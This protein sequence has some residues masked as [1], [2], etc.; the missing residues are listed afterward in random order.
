M[1]AR[2]RASA[3]LQGLQFVFGALSGSIPQAFLYVVAGGV[4]SLAVTFGLAVK[5]RLPEASFIMDIVGKVTRRFGR[6]RAR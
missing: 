4:V 3:C 5:L 6:K 1:R 2:W